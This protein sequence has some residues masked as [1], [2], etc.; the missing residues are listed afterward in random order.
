M[1]TIEQIALYVSLKLIKLA[2]AS[3]MI[4]NLFQSKGQLFKMI[5]HHVFNFVGCTSNIYLVRSGRVTGFQAMLRFE[6]KKDTFIF[7]PLTA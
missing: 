2:T 6:A 4:D 5:Y 3:Y 7:Y 1:V